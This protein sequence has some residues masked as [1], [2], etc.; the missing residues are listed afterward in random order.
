M[1]TIK[2]PVLV[3]GAGPAGL[4]ASC[5]LA[6]QGIKT[7]TVTRYRGVANSPRAH[8]TNQRTMEVFRDLGISD[9]VRRLATPNHL[10]GNNVWA[11]SFAGVE[12]ARLQT[13]GTSPERK[14]DYELASPESMCNAPQHLLEPVL[15]DVARERGAQFLFSTELQEICQGESGVTALLIDRVSG[16]SVRVEADYAVGADGGNSL[17]AAQCGFEFDGQ[18]ALG[19]AVNCWL[20]VDLSRYTAHRPGVLYWMTQPGNNFW[21]GSGTWI[22]VRPWNEWVLLFMYDPAQG[23]PDLDEASVIERARATIGD[24]DLPIRVKSVAKWQINHM[25]A[26]RMRKARVFLAGDAAHRHPPAN[27]LGTN[28]SIQDAFNLAWKLA[29]V[30]KGQAEGSLLETYNDERQPV[31]R[32]VV[33]RA[34]KSVQDML[35]ISQALGFEPG[36]SEAEGWANVDELFSNT[37]EGRRRRQALKEAV[38]LQNYQ[39]NC[40]GVEMGQRYVSPAVV[41]DGAPEQAPERDPELYYTPSARPGACLPHAWVER[42]RG[43]QRVST[44]DLVGNARFVLLTGLDDARWRTAVEAVAARLGIRLDVVS[45]G[46]PNSDAQDVEGRWQEL[47][48]LS[49]SGCL[50]VRPDFHVAWRQLDDARASTETLMSV[51]QGLLGRIGGVIHTTSKMESVHVS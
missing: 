44:L 27:G 9:R 24:K 22:C 18:M 45:I 33:D 1:R 19:A 28:T 43:R 10:M 13:W 37:A 2:V 39:F 3:V 20:E 12:I 21:V 34:M 47:S 30:I 6:T 8:I 41:P 15:L 14:A 5:L 35:P 7:L 25:V 32:T 50:L 23:E 31:A 46:G 26:R 48:G 42:K 4:A 51:M 11:T 16:E 36:Q 38:C 40:H 49:D 17:V 29:A